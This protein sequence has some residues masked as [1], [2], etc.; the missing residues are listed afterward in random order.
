MRNK[1]KKKQLQEKNEEFN[2]N[3]KTNEK[4]SQT[5]I[6]K[7]NTNK[8]IDK[9]HKFV[10]INDSKKE[11]KSNPYLNKNAS[12]ISFRKE[13]SNY[14]NFNKK[15]YDNN[16]SNNNKNEIQKEENN[17][18]KTFTIQKIKN[19]Y[20][21][22]NKYNNKDDL[23]NKNNNNFQN[24]KRIIENYHLT[25]NNS[26]KYNTIYINSGTNIR[27]KNTKINRNI[28]SNIKYNLINNS[29]NNQINTNNKSIVIKENNNNNKNYQKLNIMD[30]AKNMNNYNN[31]SRNRCYLNNNDYFSNRK[32][33]NLN[34][35]NN[36]SINDKSNSL[37]IISEKISLLN[38]YEDNSN[39]LQKDERESLKDKKLLSSKNKND[40][41]EKN[42]NYFNI[43]ESEIQEE[44]DNSKNDNNKNDKN[45][46]HNIKK[47]NINNNTFYKNKKIEENNN[48]NQLYKSLN[49]LNILTPKISHDKRHYKNNNK[50]NETD[51]NVDKNYKSLRSSVNITKDDDIS[52]K[53]FS[54]NNN[55]IDRIKK[56]NYT[57]ILTKKG[58][59]SSNIC[60][61]LRE[62]KDNINE[63][64]NNINLR[65]ENNNENLDYNKIKP[66]ETINF[67]GY[68]TS[69]TAKRWNINKENGSIVKI[70]KENIIKNDDKIINN[71]QKKDLNINLNNNPNYKNEID[72]RSP[73]MKKNQSLPLKSFKFLVHQA[74]YNDLIKDS[75]NKY[76][77]ANKKSNNNSNA[78]Y[79]ANE[80]LTLSTE[81]NFSGKM[82]YN[83]VFSEII[84]FSKKDYF[85]SPMS[86]ISNF[87]FNNENYTEDENNNI[88]SKNK[89]KIS[90]KQKLIKTSKSDFFNN[91][92]N[93][94]FDIDKNNN[95]YKF[96]NFF[97][98]QKNKRKNF[99][100]G[101]INNNIY[102]TTLN[103]YKINDNNN[104]E[105][106]Q[107]K[108]ILT[109]S[110][111]ANI[112]Y[113]NNRRNNDNLFKIE[114]NNKINNENYNT[115]NNYKDNNN[116]IPSL[117]HS[118]DNIDLNLFFNLEKKLLLL[119]DKIDE[120]KICK[121]ECYDYINYYFENQIDEHILKLFINNHNRINIINYIKLEILCYL[122]CYDISYS[123]FFNQAAIL[124]K[125]I[126][127]ILNNN[128]LL[129][130]L[131]FL[132]NFNKKIIEKKKEI[133][134]REKIIIND[135]NAIIKNNLT[136]RIDD[137]NINEL[138]I[139][140]SINN[141]TKNINNY[142][143]M[144]LDN[145]YKEYYTIKNVYN[146]N[147]KYK[148]PNCIN[149]NTN[150]NNLDKKII[151]VLF[152]YDSYRLLNSYKIN[153]L[154]KFFDIFL[155]RTKIYNYET[156]TNHFPHSNEEIDIFHVTTSLP[157][158]KNS[159]IKSLVNKNKE[160]CL[161][162]NRIYILPDLN[163]IK[164]K[165]SLILT[166]NEV[167]IFFN[168]NNN[169]YIQRP[170]L[171]DFLNE[172]K[173]IFE[174]I[175]VN[176]EFSNYEEQII[177]NIQKGNNFFEYILNRNHG[178]DN[179]NNFIQD[180]ISLNRNIKHFI[181][182]DTTI[183]RFQIHK[184]N[185]LTIKPF[186]GDIRND[187]N[188]LLFLSQLLQKIRNDSES[189]EDI[190]ISINKYKKSFIYSKIA[191]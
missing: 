106:S 115:N 118:D 4:S 143:K 6:R 169:S 46:L 84:D 170:G 135:L 186:Y 11:S 164:Y 147:N 148:F 72:L 15:F 26:Q 129:I 68:S 153:D 99:T 107:I 108:S 180:L 155:D 117:I 165:Y 183:N 10:S 76:Y 44:N 167:L 140:Q 136:I 90:I 31:I 16:N 139:I 7:S 87:C 1:Y 19:N 86:S 28:N 177:E 187:K 110:I 133:S 185:I 39:S 131:L 23:L 18:E 17:K 144:I 114:H 173:E 42:I 190:R 121:N 191:K 27:D 161:N 52:K 66:N 32:N 113:K 82:K 75:F 24:N 189:S 151:I 38:S 163:K 94:S 130:I 61:S 53:T 69:K 141:N 47:I 43:I 65:Y 95:N 77:E 123:K 157:I 35:N 178:I 91:V 120:Y 175:L 158:S 67:D 93:N 62:L 81:T 3:E 125:S 89:P 22:D 71:E 174:L 70:K 64:E 83:N 154:K 80:S 128:F 96:N 92:M 100:N 98:N 36:F 59:N 56:E 184:N 55:I 101:I 79:N 104:D 97:S 181:I 78:N 2:I 20:F 168:K 171:Y 37:S 102:S 127:N 132:T 111:K 179:I 138:Y 166:L 12:S 57:F 126:I 54:S 182:I 5:I 122:L 14:D 33:K 146:I 109:P 34:I 88:N 50:N 156:E 172:M 160:I 29:N 13:I 112:L 162:K 188:T 21:K 116:I 41:S 142:Y 149:T 137:E 58:K 8:T 45:I 30:N 73:L 176:T 145:L 124:I 103:I 40:N 85:K 51:I 74:N 49:I 119:I 9:Y 152:F 48:N 134:Q 150:Y 159:S 25:K 60:N 105:L 63:T